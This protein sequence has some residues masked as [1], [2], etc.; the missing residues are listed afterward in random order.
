MLQVINRFIDLLKLV[1]V[2]N[3]VIE[4]QLPFAVPADENRRRWCA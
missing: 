3:Q 2:G 1:T 4:F